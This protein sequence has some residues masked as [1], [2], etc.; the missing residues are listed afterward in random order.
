MAVILAIVH[1]PF[2]QRAFGTAPILLENWTFLL[3]LTP[4]VLLADEARKALQR[5]REKARSTLRA[6]L[7]A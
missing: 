6:S 2:L 4:A 1:V 5:R 3:A 7:P